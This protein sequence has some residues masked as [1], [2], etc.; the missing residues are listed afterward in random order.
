MGKSNKLTVKK[1]ESLLKNGWKNRRG[2]I[3]RYHVKNDGNGLD[4][5]FRDDSVSFVHQ[6]VLNGARRFRGL[7]SWPTVSLEDARLKRDEDK[8]LLAEGIDPKVAHK[9]KRQTIART[10]TVMQ[11]AERWIAVHD[12]EWGTE[13]YAD[14]IRQRLNQYVK[15]HIGDLPI[16]DIQLADIETVLV[17]IWKTMRPTASRI[18]MHL[19]DIIDWSID[20]EVRADKS[21][22]AE[23]KRLKSS[24]SFKK[25]KVKNYASLFYGQAPEFVAKLRAGNGVKYRV[26]EFIVLNAVRVGDICGGGKKHSLPMLWGHVD[27]SGRS[28]RIPDTKKGKPLTVPLSEPAM[29]VLAEMQPYRDP[30]TDY[31]FPG[32]KRGTVI[33]DATLR[34]LLQDLGY[35]G[36]ATTHGFRSTFSTWASETTAFPKDVVEMALAH[37]QGALDAAYMRGDLLD[38]RRRLMN[39]WG[40]FLEGKAVSRGGEL[41]A[42][43]A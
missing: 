42:L 22:P 17:P 15:P 29:R 1:I 3:T 38:K 33:S 34:V 23:K 35:A 18:R 28:W 25:R 16:A 43:S 11:A 4:V 26:L 5:Q 27:M 39:A 36:S 37:S 10:L 19:E 9:Q 20:K 14:Q 24:V 7:G 8:K 30:S 13:R 41:I 40:D 12:A 6:Y 31:V 21:N 2:E 32:A